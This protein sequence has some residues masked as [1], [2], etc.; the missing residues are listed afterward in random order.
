MN[1]IISYDID[2]SILVTSSCRTP[3]SISVSLG[4]KEMKKNKRTSK[5]SKRKCW[6]IQFDFDQTYKQKHIYKYNV[7]FKTLLDISEFGKNVQLNLW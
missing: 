6:W 3:L 5:L 7:F 1:L 4:R 2:F